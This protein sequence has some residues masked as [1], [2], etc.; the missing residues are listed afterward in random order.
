MNR[1]K[2]GAAGLAVALS[3]LIIPATVHAADRPVV[4]EGNPEAQTIY[5]SYADLNL[6]DASGLKRLNRRVRTAA[7]RLCVEPGLQTVRQE[8]MDNACRA[9]AIAGADEQIRLAAVN[10]GNRQFAATSGY[11]I[12]VARR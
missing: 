10:F 4:V 6:A 9:D 2:I 1:M 11:Q 12:K 8:M 3:A 7:T 5:V